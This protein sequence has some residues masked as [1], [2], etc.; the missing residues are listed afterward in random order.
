M[1]LMHKF[2]VNVVLRLIGLVALLATSGSHVYAYATP[3][4]FY[5]VERAVE[6]Q[7]AS[8][9]NRVAQEGLLAMLTRVTGLLSV[10][11]TESVRAALANPSR[12][13]SE[14]KFFTKDDE[15]MLRVTYQKSAIMNLVR[16][17][18]LPIWWTSRPTVLAW[19]A[20]EE[21]G[22][23]SIL[24]AESEHPLRD[25]LEARARARGLE[26]RLPLMDVDDELSISPSEVWGDVV[27]SVESASSRYDPDMT[28]TCRMQSRL[29]L[30]GR[31]LAGDCRYWLDDE[32][33]VQNFT[34]EQFFDVATVTVDGLVERFVAK[35]GVLSRDPKRWEV[36]IRGLQEV[37]QYAAL[38]RYLAKLDFVDRVSVAQLAR[39]HM[40]VRFDTRAEADQFLMLLTSEGTLVVDDFNVEPGV[41]LIWRG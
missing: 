13:Y 25:E 10:P 39:E 7:S 23:R 40:V 20:V 30:A 33:I 16:E 37:Q 27:A 31:S 11:R 12:Y 29:S 9:R 22:R 5:S 1:E 15:T 21:N 17:N 24:G 36:R 41:Q 4:W 2:S 3:E 28:M 14:F 6:N 26:L 38:M 8:E 32:P 34:A 19:V 18:Q 35:F